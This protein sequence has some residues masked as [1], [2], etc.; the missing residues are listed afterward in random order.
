MNDFADWFSPIV[1]KELR[2]GM[3]AR[4]FLGIFL[5]IQFFMIICVVSSLGDG[6]RSGVTAIFWTFIG[7]AILFA[8]PLRG[9]AALNGEMKGNTMELMLLTQLSAWR[10][11]AGKWVAL[12][13]QTLLLVCAV[14]PYVVLR[15]FLGGV[16]LMDDLVCLGF[17]LVGSALAT[18]LT[19]SLSGFMQSLF[20]RIGVAALFPVGF[21]ILTAIL[22]GPLGRS[23][24]V[25][26]RTWVVAAAVLGPLLVLELFE[27]GVAKIAPAAENHATRK[28]LI[29]AALLAASLVLG[30]FLHG[31]AGFLLTLGCIAAMPICITALGEETATVPSIY[32]PFVRRGFLGRALGRLFYP[33]WASGLPFVLL[34]TGVVLW[35]AHFSWKDT[36]AMFRVEALLESLFVPLAIVRLCFRRVLSLLPYYL[37]LQLMLFV[38]A[39]TLTANFNNNAPQLLFAGCLPTLGLLL[40]LWGHSSLEPMG[41]VGVLITLISLFA[42]FLY[43]LKEWKAI[44]AMEREAAALDALPPAG[45]QAEEPLAEAAAGSG[46]NG[47]GTP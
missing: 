39:I 42:L 47:S 24:S 37:G 16:D 33:G 7:A 32:R 6:S 1:V 3:R 45:A 5:A 9:L 22:D 38:T 23:T 15:Y 17:M 2:Q 46:I 30:R 35:A 11:T 41:G 26:L 34:A 12:V 19:V 18:A 28:R 29:A 40:H 31:D 14:L 27:L 25:A 8:M 43:S 44:A 13:L 36:S 4:A 10:I 20:G 21:A